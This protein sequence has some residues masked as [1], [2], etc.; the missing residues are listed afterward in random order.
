MV[1]LFIRRGSIAKV[2]NKEGNGELDQ[3]T[4]HIEGFQE[5]VEELRDL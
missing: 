3:A 2:M 4:K 5:E 1:E